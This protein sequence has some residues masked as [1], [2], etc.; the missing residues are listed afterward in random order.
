ME[1]KNEYNEEWTGNPFLLASWIAKAMAGELSDEEQRA[2]D[3]WRETSERNR[4]LYDR[5]VDREG[6]ESKQKHFTT[7]DKVSGWQGYS[8][9]LRKTEKKAMRRRVFLRYAAVLLIPLGVAVYGVLHSGEETVSLADLKQS[10]PGEPG[11]S[12]C[13][14]RGRWL[15][16]LR[17]PGLYRVGKI[18]SLITREKLFPIKIQE[19]RL[20]WTL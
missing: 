13:C 9:K 7:F 1:R 14:L 19:I 20:R 4:Q 6:R 15:I 12:W 5:I 3:D 2:L 17:D 16:W 11:Q 18:Q 8:K 10:L